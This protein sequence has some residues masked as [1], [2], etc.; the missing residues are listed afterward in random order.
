MESQS[1]SNRN[2]ATEVT[3]EVE[4]EAVFLVERRPSSLYLKGQ[5]VREKYL[6]CTRLLDYLRKLLSL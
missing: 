2:S 5:I 1:I 4:G 6:D 3:L